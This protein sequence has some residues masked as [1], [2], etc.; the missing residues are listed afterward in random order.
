[1]AYKKILIRIVFPL[2]TLFLI[3]CENK[4]EDIESLSKKTI[5]V[6]RATDVTILYTI[7]S[8]TKSRITAPL[9]LRY[10]EINPYI[11]FTEHI[12]AD[13]FDESLQ[14]ESQMNARYAKYYENESRIFLQDSVVV[15]NSKG[16]T[17]F[18]R[19]LYWDRKQAGQEFH[20]DKPI[21]IRTPTHIIDGDG[22]DAPQ[23]FKS[24]H[25]VNGR[26]IV[27]VPASDLPE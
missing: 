23:D 3:S 16:D 26:G 14:T 15:F 20:T 21:R 13:F 18:C 6:E 25:V 7:G 19:E 5:G 4:R 2:I 8:Q 24:W 10:A 1:M 27:R 11:E 22:L 17:L 12:H 9:M